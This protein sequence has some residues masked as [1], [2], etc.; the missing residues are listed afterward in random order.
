MIK[1]KRGTETY[2]YKPVLKAYEG[3][4]RQCFSSISELF[5]IEDIL[6]PQYVSDFKFMTNEKTG[7]VI[8]I[9]NEILSNNG[10][11]STT[12]KTEELMLK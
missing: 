12:S 3:E 8:K 4:K 10:S 7:Q 5:R 6:F 2:E 1:V 11:F 9:D